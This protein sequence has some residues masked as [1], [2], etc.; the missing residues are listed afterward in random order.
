MRHCCDVMRREWSGNV[1][2][3]RIVARFRASLT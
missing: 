1:N 2:N 3:I